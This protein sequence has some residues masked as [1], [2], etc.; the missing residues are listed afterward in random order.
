MN[1][2]EN[3]IFSANIIKLTVPGCAIGFSM[4]QMNFFLVYFQFV[5]TRQNVI[6]YLMN[7]WLANLYTCV[8]LWVWRMKYIQLYYTFECNFDEF[9]FLAIK[10]ILICKFPEF[11]V[12][13]FIEYV[14]LKMEAIKWFVRFTIK[15]KLGYKMGL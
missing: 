8:L 5:A 9:F 3:Y 2:V 6:K 7:V 12:N 4:I 14:T 10:Y 15:I 11:W 1:L 13:Q